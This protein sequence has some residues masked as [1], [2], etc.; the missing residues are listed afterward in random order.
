MVHRELG[1]RGWRPGPDALAALTVVALLAPES[2]AYAQIARIPLQYG[3]VAAPLTLLAY[4]LIGCSKVL[5]VGATAAT[6]VL[7]GAIVAQVTSDPAKRLE[8]TAAVA[9]LAGAFLVVTGLAHCGFIVRFLTPEALTGFL[10]GLA[11]VV[12]VRQVGVVVHV[13]AGSGD[14]FVKAWHVLSSPAHWHGLSIAVGLSTLGALLLLEWRLP[15]LPGTLI[16]LVLAWTASVVAGL[17]DR[18]VAVVGSIPS[19]TPSLKTPHLSTHEWVH[20]AA[21][22]LGLA[23]IVFVMSYSVMTRTATEDEP[24]PDANREMIAVGVANVLAGLVGGLASGGSPSASA[25]ARMAGARTKMTAVI[26]AGV[27]LVVAALCTPVFT[28]LPEPALAAVVIGAVRGFLA[29]PTFRRYLRLDRSSLLI[30]GTALLGVL[31]FD[32]L[33]GLLLAVAVSLILFI[34]RASKL[35]VS[36]LGRI[37]GS[38]TYLAIERYPAAIRTPGLLILRP[39]GELFFANINRL[40]SVVDAAAQAVGVRVLLLDLTATF[41][42]ELSEL[43]GLRSLRDRLSRR[44][45]ELRFVHLYLAASDAVKRSELADVVTYTDTQAAVESFA[46]G[47]LPAA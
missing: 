39:D 16:V 30:A 19:I 17:K 47:R 42:L 5:A 21:G 4:A 13:P 6:A 35:R 8:L 1:L 27:M 28:S 36:E 12:I 2:V 41:D 18:G 37:D 7:S 29:V 32:L 14:A 26:A 3:L 22:A 24:L 23:L 43:D 40:S 11:V 34:A 9:L 20:L 15:K 38:T 25:A 10:A 33:P 44:G 46:E 45:V 31:T